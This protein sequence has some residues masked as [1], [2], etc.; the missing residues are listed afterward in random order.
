MERR[1]CFEYIHLWNVKKYCYNRL[2]HN[3]T[4]ITVKMLVKYY[5][6]LLCVCTVYT[7]NIFM[8]AWF[9]FTCIFNVRFVSVWYIFAGK[10]ILNSTLRLSLYICLCVNRHLIWERICFLPTVHSGLLWPL[11][12]V[13]SHLVVVK[14]NIVDQTVIAAGLSMHHHFLF[15]YGYLDHD[16]HVSGLWEETVEIKPGWAQ[17][18]HTDKT[19]VM[20]GSWVATA[21][22]SVSPDVSKINRNYT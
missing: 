10:Y 21:A 22:V 6:E 14:T 3:S 11:N 15:E 4:D 17:D 12:D 16:F 1:E 8:G 13:F 7:V 9:F 20:G 2:A 19:G 5:S 18:L